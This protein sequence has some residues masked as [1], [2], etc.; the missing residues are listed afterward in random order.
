[1]SQIMDECSAANTVAIDSYASLGNRELAWLAF[2]RRVLAMVEDPTVPLLERVKFLGIMG[3]LHYEFF[4]K[5]ASRLKRQIRKRPDKR[6]MDG[7][8]PAQELAACT[9]EVNEQLAILYR[10]MQLEILPGL[11]DAGVPILRWQE[12]TPTQT[13]H[14]RRYFRE[15]VLPILIPLAVDAEHPFPFISNLGIN[16][17]VQI[18]DPIDGHDRFVRIKVPVNRPRWVPL[19]DGSGFVPLE[20]VMRANL[21][22]MYPQT[23]PRAVYVF[24]VTRGAE[25]DPGV[26]E[27]ELEDSDVV[28]M[29]GGHV[30]YVSAFLKARRFAQVVRLQV[31]DAM[32]LYLRRW[33]AEQLQ[34]DLSDVLESPT[35]LGI[36]DFL[37]FKPDA[38]PKHFFAPHTPRNHP[39]LAA[40][41]DIF[42]EI[43]S[44]DILV[45]SPYTSF[46]ATVLRFLKDAATDPS[47]L[48]IQLTI[49]RTSSDSPIV[50]AL[51]EAARRGKQVAVLVEITA[52]FDEAPNIAWGAYLE[53]EG[54]HVAYGIEQ[55]KTHVKLALVV[56]EEEGSLRRYAHLGTGNY[57]TGTARLYEDLGILTA[58][59]VLCEDAAVVFAALTGAT[60]VTGMREMLVAPVNLRSGFVGLIRREAEHAKA[61]RP[62]GIEAKMNQLQDRG[63][64]RELYLASQAGVPITLNVRGLCTLRPGVPG[65]SDNI[66]VY[67]IVWR[68]LEHSRIYRFK[69]GGAPEFFIGSA[70]WMERNLDRRVESIVPVKDKTVQR[71]LEHILDVY[72]SDNVSAW[73]CGPD[74]TYSRRRPPQGE[75]RRV[76]QE[77]LASEAAAKL[78]AAEEA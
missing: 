68:F 37:R 57:H 18:P 2:A 15:A 12:L 60:P 63:I 30:R 26:L 6:S 74:M 33:L 3:V 21:S 72:R 7:R 32:P 39:R 76:A 5:R 49:Y 64:I 62:C 69:N 28:E 44:G 40:S 1:M 24:R 35:L 27:S 67:G 10:V 38:S 45:H 19:P 13:A 59:P 66:R 55:L 11:K 29:P 75:T 70:D 42:A 48:A 14:L 65:L 20:E 23:P 36:S 41:Q 73:D 16:L 78:D 71:E 52:R 9:H 54:V 22:E 61:G 17:A 77:V 50:A 43:R 34:T 47:V 8:T 46:D 58:D 56:R 4:T 51:A 53:S 25:G 31:E